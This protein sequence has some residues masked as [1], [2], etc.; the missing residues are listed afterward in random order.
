MIAFLNLL[1]LVSERS[2]KYTCQIT[3]CCEIK[4]E[5]IFRC[6]PFNETSDRMGKLLS[7]ATK[8]CWMF[9]GTGDF[10]Y[11]KTLEDVPNIAN[12]PQNIAN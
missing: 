9:E 1:E 7:T 4:N 5:K 6:V 12:Y 3:I 2:L 8:T 11:R 10:D